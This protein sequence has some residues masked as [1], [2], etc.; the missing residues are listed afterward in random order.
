MLVNIRDSSEAIEV[1]GTVIS[2][3][4]F[5]GLDRPQE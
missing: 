1:T 5:L 3:G 4:R 2:S